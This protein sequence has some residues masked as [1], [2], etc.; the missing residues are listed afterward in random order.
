MQVHQVTGPALINCYTPERARSFLSWLHQIM[1]A[2]IDFSTCL[3][4][5]LDKLPLCFT[6]MPNEAPTE[7]NISGHSQA[8]LSL[9]GSHMAEMNLA[10]VHFCTR[11]ENDKAHPNLVKELQQLKEKGREGDYLVFQA[12]NRPGTYHL[13][14]LLNAHLPPPSNTVSTN[15]STVTP[16]ENSSSSSF[17]VIQQS[18][19]AEGENNE[20]L[21]ADAPMRTELDESACSQLILYRQQFSYKP[22]ANAKA[23]SFYYLDAAPEPVDFDASRDVVIALEKRIF[24]S[25]NELIRDYELDIETGQSTTTKFRLNQYPQVP[26][27]ANNSEFDCFQLVSTNQFQK[28]VEMHD[29]P[30]DRVLERNYWT[31]PQSFWYSPFPSSLF[32]L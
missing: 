9:R 32:P 31:L 13:Y 2:Y 30:F 21:K 8:G 14:F 3:C 4:F 19:A 17:D 15:P 29:T 5:S 11:R 25:F 22:L 10:G 26:S 7:F 16:I 20:E 18:A 6:W 12:Y 27:L 23:N 1:H 24:R 28:S